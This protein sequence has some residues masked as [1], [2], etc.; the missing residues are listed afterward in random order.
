MRG[1]VVITGGGTGGHVFP[2]QAIAEALVARGLDARDLRYVG[3]RRG[4]EGRLLGGGPVELTVLPGRGIRRSLRPR[5]LAVSTGA[6]LGLAVAVV[7]AAVLVRRWRPRAAVSVG[8]YASFAMCTAAVLWRVPLVLVD[9][10]AVPG[11]VHRTFSRF[12]ARRCVA[13]GPADTGVVVTGTPLRA[14]IDDLDRGEAARARARAAAAP[15]ISPGRLVVVV[16]TGSLGARRV[17]DAVAELAVLWASRSDVTIIHVTGE[18]DYQRVAERRH[19]DG[20]LDYRVLAF[21]DMVELWAVADLAVCRAGAIT[22]AELTRL[23]IPSILVPLPGAPGDHQGRNAEVLARAG[24]ARVIDDA[25]CDA[26]TL[27]A[28]IDELSRVDVLAAMARAADVLA[29]PGAASAIAAV[30]EEVAR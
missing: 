14:A 10:D 23:A 12:A 24:A 19:A 3:S 18:R 25:A 6:A 4:Q 2:M 8:G 16:M 15:P 20:A 9:F 29:H 26:P 27:A 1:P 17:N 21:A 13:F 11:A 5:D 22:V 30:V 28:V 7:R